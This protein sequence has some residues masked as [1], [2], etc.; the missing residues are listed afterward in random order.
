MSS[1]TPKIFETGAM[2]MEYGLTLVNVDTVIADAGTDILT[3]ATDHGLL[4][5]APVQFTTTTT[6]PAPLAVLTTYYAIVVDSDEIQVATTLANAKLGTDIDL[7]DTGTGVHTLQKNASQSDGWGSANSER[8]LYTDD[9]FPWL[10]FSN[11]LNI[12]TEEDNSV[13]TRA[14][15]TT[16][17][18]VGKTVDNPVSFHA[19]FKGLNRF[20]YW[21]WGFEN[22]VKKVV[23]FKAGTTPFSGDSPVPGDACTDTDVNNFTFLRTEQ[24]RDE[25]IYIFE[26]DDSVAPTLQTGVL[27]HA[28]PG[29]TFTFTSHSSLMYEHIYELDSFGRRYRLYNTAEK[30]LLSLSATDKRNLMATFGKRMSEYDLRYKNAMCK[31]FSFKFTAAGLSQYD[32]NYMGFTETRDNY[33]SEDWSLVSGLGDA[34]LVSA[35]FEFMFKLGETISLTDGEL[36]GLTEIGISDADL[37]IVTPLQSL[38]DTVSG[39]SLAEPVLE[40]KYGVKMTGTISRHTVQTYQTIRDAQ[41]KIAAHLVTNQGWYMQEWML[42]EATLSEAGPDDGDVAQ[43]P[44]SLESG[45]VEGTNEFSDWLYGVTEIHDSPVIFRVRDFSSVNQMTLF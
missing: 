24:T 29:W 12:A 39:L 21:M 10:T 27:T 31:N 23:A 8:D 38:Q 26:A 2:K 40:G 4:T 32:C 6:L 35:H 18:M 43:E 41:T 14:F 30:A 28:G 9:A 33:N 42:K 11:K 25:K 37:S 15:K 19:R 16:P 20:H 22:V 44:L 36:T 34:S 3:V 1:P 17:R 5:G 45:F 7:T 13:T